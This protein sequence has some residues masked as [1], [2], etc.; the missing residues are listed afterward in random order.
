MKSFYMI[1]F[2]SLCLF[3]QP[4]YTLGWG[5][6]GHRV[7]SEI[8]E[9]HLSKKAKK[10][11]KA[12]IGN[13]K[14]AYWSNWADFIKSDPAPDLLQTH[15]WH[16]VNVPGNLS[17][18]DFIDTLVQ[19]SDQNLYKAY[20]RLRREAKGGKATLEEKRKQL[21]FILHLF[22]DAHQPMHIGRKE[23]LGGNL[24]SVTYFGRKTNIHAVWDSALI[25][26]EQYSYTEYADVLDIAPADYRRY[27]SGTFQ[28]WMYEAYQLT[29]L[30][31]ADVAHNTSLSYGYMYKF[32]DALES[33]LLKAGLRLAKELNDIYG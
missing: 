19:S 20:L 30:I 14:M 28:D 25:D 15:S 32:K 12:I 10:N 9:R 23:D 17:Y 18:E 26:G 31:Y 16:Y 13:Q 1:V 22:A 2:G 7:I 24:V 27:S 3:L 21:Y 33:C 11:I 4:F 29:N 5:T 6:T 8:A